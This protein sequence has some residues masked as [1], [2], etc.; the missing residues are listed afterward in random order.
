M[1]MD[2]KVFISERGR[3]SSYGASLSEIVIEYFIWVFKKF[4]KIFKLKI[5]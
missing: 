1:D 3:I 4:K 2:K 5:F